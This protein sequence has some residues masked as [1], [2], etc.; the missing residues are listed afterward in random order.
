MGGTVFAGSSI[1]SRESRILILVSLLQLPESKILIQELASAAGL[2]PRPTSPS[3]S[4]WLLPQFSLLST[5]FKPLTLSY[6][7]QSFTRLAAFH[8]FSQLP[9]TFSHVECLK[10]AKT[11]DPLTISTSFTSFIGS[12]KTLYMHQS[13][14]NENREE[15]V[16]R[17]CL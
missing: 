10:M 13:L 5:F 11:S 17:R 6:S 1:R 4:Y 8:S 16:A 2:L 3:V 15:M 7:Q 12:N 14:N 9:S